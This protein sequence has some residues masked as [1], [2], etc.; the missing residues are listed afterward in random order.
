MGAY[1]PICHQGQHDSIGF[2]AKGMGCFSQSTAQRNRIC[3]LLD[4][5]KILTGYFKMSTL[6]DYQIRD[7]VENHGA[8]FPYKEDQLNP[9]S[10]DVTLGGTVLT[11]VAGEPGTWDGVDLD[12]G[13]T[14][15]LQPNEFVL[16][17][18]R[19]I[20]RLPETIEAIFC[21][22]SS[23]GR[24]GYNHMLAAYCDPGFTG[25]VTL[26]IHNCTRYTPLPLYRGMRIGQL[27]FAVLDSAPLRDYSKT[28][29]YHK[30]LEPMPSKG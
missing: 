12:D 28:G 3:D 17:C 14:Y 4:T 19:E 10:Y 11:E 1:W 15:W 30:D 23:R 29:R 5:P 21:L 9:A 25:R 6:V 2:S 20:I 18:T 27:R 8:I 7:L 16:S 24:E 13:S 26:E 22:K